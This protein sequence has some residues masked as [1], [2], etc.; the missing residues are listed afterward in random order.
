MLLYLMRHGDAVS[1]ARTDQER[2]LSPLGE[3]QASSMVPVLLD[4]PPKRLLVSP[5]LRA[6]QTANL[7]AGGLASHDIELAIETVEFITP[8]DSP[9]YALRNLEPLLQNSG[10]ILV[11]SHQPL[12]GC[13]I[14][15]LA[16]GHGL[17]M[18]VGTASIACL[19]SDT[20]GAGTADLIWFQSPSI[21]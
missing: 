7:V 11:V 14:S 12:V 21:H 19:K 2:P 13:L 16:E 8:D 18:P 5:Y 20:M 4:Q 17:G 3:A 6:Q 1:K 10:P 9:H 15:L